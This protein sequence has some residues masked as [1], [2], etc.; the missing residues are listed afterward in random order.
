MAAGPGR[1]AVPLGLIAAV[2]GGRVSP[3]EAAAGLC[4]A[5]AVARCAWVRQDGALGLWCLPWRLMSLP[6]AAMRGLCRRFPKVEVLSRVR[7]LVC[8]I[9]VV[10]AWQA[11]DYAVAV[12]LAGVGA[13]SYLQPALERSC[14]VRLQRVGDRAVAEA[15]LGEAYLQLLVTVGQ[16]VSLERRALLTAP[17]GVPAR[18]AARG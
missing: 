4:H 6:V 10:Q 16:T 11:G 18:S 13:M 5:A 14:A 9:A 17:S 7:L 12:M 8:G 2:E 15:G 3:L 1:V